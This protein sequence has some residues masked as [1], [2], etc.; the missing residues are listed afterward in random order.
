MGGGGGW[1]GLHN[2]DFSPVLLII[3]LILAFKSCIRI[4]DEVLRE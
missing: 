3:C 1:G 4:R 2:T